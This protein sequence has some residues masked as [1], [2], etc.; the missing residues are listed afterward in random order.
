M[1]SRTRS[2]ITGALA[3]MSVLTAA[4]TAG[5][6]ETSAPRDTTEQQQRLVAEARA[7]AGSFA[8]ELKKTLQQSI[9][10]GSLEAAVSSCHV[11]APAIAAGHSKD[12]WQIGRTALKV[13]NPNNRPDAWERRVMEGFQ[14]RLQQGESFGNLEVSR[15]SDGE[16]RY[17]KAIPTAGLCVGCHGDNIAEPVRKRIDALYPNDAARGFQVGDM[18]GAFTIRLTLDQLAPDQLAPDQLTP[19]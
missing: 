12:H 5:A 10:T 9:K 4:S 1:A 17:M 13:R 6:G 14:Q 8:A 7:R 18:R 3:L 11:A 19:K 2:C 15:I 16:F